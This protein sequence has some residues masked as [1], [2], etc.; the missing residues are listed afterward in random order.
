MMRKDFAD[1]SSQDVANDK[2]AHT[3]IEFAQR[4][5]ASDPNAC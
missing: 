3:A 2:G 4:N 1:E 5:E